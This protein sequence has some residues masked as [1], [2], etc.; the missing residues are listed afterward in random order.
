MKT[1]V[2][3]G[4]I[5]ITATVRVKKMDCEIAEGILEEIA[6]CIDLNFGEFKPDGLVSADVGQTAFDAEWDVQ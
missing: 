6:S 3:T 4:L 5:S 1:Y 2:V